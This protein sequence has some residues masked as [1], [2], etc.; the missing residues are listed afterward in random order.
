[1]F[2]IVFL[3]FLFSICFCQINRTDIV[4]VL[5]E[6]NKINIGD[7]KDG[8]Y[9]PSNTWVNGFTI[10]SS[11]TKYGIMTIKLI[12]VDIEQRERQGVYFQIPSSYETSD[13][14]FFGQWQ[15]EVFC[16]QNAFA[17]GKKKTFT[18]INDF[19]TVFYN[20]QATEHGQ[21]G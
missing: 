8:I 3:L 9:C 6:S 2:T 4:G 12:C 1:M 7:W 18:K 16:N 13:L 14:A 17:T 15:K 20:Y 19:L 21:I 5:Y 11:C 10:F